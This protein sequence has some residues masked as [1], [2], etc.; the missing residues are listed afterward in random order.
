MVGHK[1]ESI[2]RRYTI[3]D[4]GL[5][6]EAANKLS[7]FLT[8]QHAVTAKVVDLGSPIR[9]DSDAARER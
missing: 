8:R 5:L 3:V 2:Y 7:A 9:P 1:T 6:K 4:E